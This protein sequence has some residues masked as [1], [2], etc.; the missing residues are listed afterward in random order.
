MG[1]I[2]AALERAGHEVLRFRQT[3]ARR[4]GRHDR[5]LALLQREL[6]TDFS[7]PMAR[8]HLDM[9][10][11]RLAAG[12]A[13]DAVAHLKLADD[14]HLDEPARLDK[15]LLSC[16]TL[17]EQGKAAE[18]ETRLRALESEAMGGARS[19]RRRELAIEATLARKEPEAARDLCGEA[20]E[21]L[22]WRLVAE[23]E[24]ELRQGRREN[25]GAPLERARA[26]LATRPESSWL[27]RQVDRL[28]RER[29]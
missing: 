20:P 17:L 26:L 6:Y 21:L 19:R 18:A 27:R 12:K 23:A 4:L 1:L 28:L 7:R 22:P 13:E 3:R 10:W 29:K 24:A 5:A 11:E 16:W 2:R 9:A 25:A 14:E 15:R 8:I